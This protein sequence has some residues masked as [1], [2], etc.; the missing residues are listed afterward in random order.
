MRSSVNHSVSALRMFALSALVAASLGAACADHPAPA[1][2]SGPSIAVSTSQAAGTDWPAQFEAGGVLQTRQV[3]TIA[4]RLMAPVIAVR[5]RPGDRVRKG[6]TLIELEGANLVAGAARAAAGS[7]AAQAGATAAQADVTAATAALTLAEATHAR[8]A[9]LAETRAATT[10]ELDQAAAALAA[11]KAQLAAAQARRSGALAASTAAI[12][13]E[14]AAA[15]DASYLVLTAPFDGRVTDRS[16]EPG[17]M[18][19][20]GQ[21]LLI[22]EGAA[23]DDSATSPLQLN[24]RLDAA[25]AAAIVVGQSVDVRID[26]DPADAPPIAG[27]VSEL[28]RIDT[29]GHSFG[30]KIDV[31]A[32]ARWRAGLFGRARFTGPPRRAITIPAGAVVR[33]G[34][35]AFVFVAEEGRA[36]LRAISLGESDGALVEVLDGLTA[37]ETILSSPPEQLADGARITAQGGTR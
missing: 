27:H 26:S 15:A 37:G 21:P 32:P 25:R 17:S 30:V 3:A 34:Q 24:V 2:E 13:G 29:G 4:S 7:I 36:R 12:A 35:L 11:A 1:A 9:Q 33:R 16:I 20:P 19:V 10:Q 31:A 18:A 28:S 6:Q 22:I 14:R 23:R 5:V 8:I